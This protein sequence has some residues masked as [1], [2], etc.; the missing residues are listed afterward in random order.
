[1]GRDLDTISRSGGE[2]G[3][4]NAT[5]I[6]GQVWVGHCSGRKISRAIL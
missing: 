2:V 5:T 6:L 1:M 3:E 4:G